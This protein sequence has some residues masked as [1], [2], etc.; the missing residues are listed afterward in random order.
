M[1]LKNT[2]YQYGRIAKWM[3]WSTAALFLL[4]YCTVYF[5]QWFTEPNTS[6]NMTALHLHLSIGI[7]LGVLVVLRVIWRIYS[8]S[9]SQE[10]GTRL[11]H[12]AAHLGHYA[13]YAMMIVMPITGYLGT[14][15]STDFFFMFD[16]PRFA[17]TELFKVVVVSWMDMS[18][19]EFEKPIDYLHKDLLGAWIVWMLIA[20]HI[21]AALYHHF[22]KKDRTLQKMTR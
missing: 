19:E 5:R 9:P 12:L 1:T 3:H 6:V 10:P 21:A 7:S 18:F 15:L 17:D 14:G 16:I 11:E 2:S 13:L 20:G 22:I 8:V 4:A